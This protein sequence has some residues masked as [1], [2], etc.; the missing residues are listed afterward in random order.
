MRCTHMPRKVAFL[1]LLLLI[2]AVPTLQGKDLAALENEIRVIIAEYHGEVGVAIEHIESGRSL[3][4]NGNTDFPLASVYKIP[5]MVEVFRQASEKELSLSSRIT[6]RPEM[7]HPWGRVISHFEPGLRPTVRDLMYWMM[8]V[9]DNLATDILLEK[10]GIKMVNRTLHELDLDEIRVDRPVKRL[11]LDYY[12]GPS[13]EQYYGLTGKALDPLTPRFR[14]I[15]QQRLKQARVHGPLA[16]PVVKYNKDARDTGSPLHIN[17]L[18]VKIFEGEVVSKAASEEMIAI[19]LDCRTG[20]KKI[21][22]LL[23]PG[24]AVA[25]KTGGWPTSNNDAGII[26]LPEGRGH[27]AVTVLN[28]NMNE[29]Y[30]AS[31]EM[32]A[33]IARVAY[34]F[35]VERR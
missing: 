33:R 20:E 4:I 21:K 9:S 2:L 11:L 31:E 27:L 30:P 10:V 17:A 1:G 8:V 35:F 25:H 19:M 15:M 32:I 29:D 26:F 22:G 7:Y 6:L 14:R 3:S 23:P 34:D 13:A 16:E 5:V 24:T 18:L 12:F 28:N